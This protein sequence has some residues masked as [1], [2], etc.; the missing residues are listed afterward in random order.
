[1][2]RYASWI[3]AA[4]SCAFGSAAWAWF[5]PAEPNEVAF[6]PTDA[7]FVRI[8]LPESQGE[9][10]VDEL[11]IYGPEGGANLALASAGAKA[12]ASSLIAG[13]P[14]HQVAHLNA[15]L[16]AVR[17]QTWAEAWTQP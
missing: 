3:L 5:E 10:C 17:A 9:P 12:S 6:A 15:G 13:F 8:L 2:R 7:R 11:E 14:I 16:D 1:M 4:A